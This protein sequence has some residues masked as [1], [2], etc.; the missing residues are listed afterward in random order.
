MSTS[1]ASIDT[2]MSSN[3]LYLRTGNLWENDSKF[4]SV[5]SNSDAAFSI[6]G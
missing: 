3:N 6:Y 1:P 2:M 4:F 5:R